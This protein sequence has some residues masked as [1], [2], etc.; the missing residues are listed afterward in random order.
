MH[1]NSELLFETYARPYFQAGMRVLEIGPDLAPST[2]ETLVG[3]DSIKWDTVDLADG[4]VHA[5]SQL[6]YTAT[7]EYEFPIED[8]LYD[9]VVS[10]NDDV[11]EVVI[12]REFVLGRR[13]IR[14]L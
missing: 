6:T 13:R 7:S 5:P 14:E 4:H 12:D 3:D 10:G 8:D 2:F 9:I 11:V 1:P